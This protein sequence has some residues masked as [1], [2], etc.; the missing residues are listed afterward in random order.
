[1]RS[2]IFSESTMQS[3]N[4][5]GSSFEWNEIAEIALQ[6]TLLLVDFQAH[7]TTAAKEDSVKLKEP[8]DVIVRRRKCSRIPTNL[9]FSVPS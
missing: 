7:D 3:D 9:I 8:E 5:T 6:I 4:M 1:M 2:E